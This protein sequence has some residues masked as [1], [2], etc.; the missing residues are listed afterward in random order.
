GWWS[1]MFFTA[2]IASAKCFFRHIS[3]KNTLT[4]ARRNVSRH[5]DL[6]SLEKSSRKEA[7]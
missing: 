6:A 5:Y 2:S 7:N 3:R 1:P 4:Q